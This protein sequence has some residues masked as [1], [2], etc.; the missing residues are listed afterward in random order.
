MAQLS[1][2]FAGRSGSGLQSR[3]PRHDLHC[4]IGKSGRRAASVTSPVRPCS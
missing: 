3:C 2:Q 1:P 4:I